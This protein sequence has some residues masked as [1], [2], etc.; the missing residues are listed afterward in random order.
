M[1]AGT[2][3]VRHQLLASLQVFKKYILCIFLCIHP[4]VFTANCTPGL[5]IN[6]W[7]DQWKWQW[8]CTPEHTLKATDV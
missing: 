2:K 5:K 7:E 4:Q 6:F 1:S 8:L 3:G